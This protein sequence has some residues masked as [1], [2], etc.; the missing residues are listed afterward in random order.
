MLLVAGAVGFGPITY[1]LPTYL[2]MMAFKEGMPRHKW[3]FNA[4]FVV[5]W[6]VASAAAAVGAV[7]GIVVAASAHDFFI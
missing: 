4:A 6:L 1:A 3:L 2:Y 7:Y 5:F